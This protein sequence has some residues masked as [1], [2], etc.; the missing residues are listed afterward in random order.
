MKIIRL[1]ACWLAA[2]FAWMNSSA[3]ANK[4]EGATARKAT[5][6]A[7]A[8]PFQA[9]DRALDA[10]R[11]SDMTGG[12]ARGVVRAVREATLSSRLAAKITQIPYVEGMTF[13][14]GDILVAFDCERQAAEARAAL[15]AV[16]VQAKTVETNQ[17]LD[18]F[19]S[20]GKNDLLISIA[21]LEKVT[22]E[23][24]ALQSAI[25]DC[26]V[27][28]PYNGTVVQLL[29]RPFETVSASQPL[30][31]IVDTSQIE[32]EMIV[33][34]Q[35]LQWL[36]TGRSFVFAVDENRKDLSFAVA[37]ISPSI[38]PVSKTVRVIGIPKGA[39]GGV[40]PGMSGTAK[41]SPPY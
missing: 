9:K 23:S 24:Q 16:Q 36:S 35:W 31:K 27:F 10:A 25:K 11:K 28:A 26:K 30:L 33:P 18:R 38:D 34:S 4:D 6:A 13:R 32:V 15:A 2:L 20:I 29:A 41:F 39:P 37:R 5:G 22:A 3:M 21:Q 14:Q 17:E 40:L 19:N 7:V 1:K 8:I 12:Q